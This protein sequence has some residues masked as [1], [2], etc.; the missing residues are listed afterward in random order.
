[1]GK[2]NSSLTRVKPLGDAIINNHHLVNKLLSLVMQDET[3]DFGEFV[4]C[5]I[6]YMNYKDGEEKKKEK[7]LEPSP[8]HL[9]AIID[10]ILKDEQFRSYVRKRDKSTNGNKIK[11]NKL[12][13]LDPEAK[14]VA[15]SC[16]KS[17]W[18]K[19]ETNSYPDLFI[20][21]DK[22]IIVIEGKRTEKDITSST[23]YL[24]NSSQMTRHIENALYYL[25]KKNETKRV[26]GFY[27]VEDTCNY[28]EHCTREYFRKSLDLETIQKDDVLKSTISNS[29]YGYTT[30]QEISKKLK[31]VYPKD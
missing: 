23:A 12:F 3:F 19:F 22:N 14:K 31:I 30:W 18:N 25:H 11:R 2:L 29:F 24:P 13:D 20:E 10:R 5:N 7:V 26:I 27:I 8:S 28:K 16:F 4:G 21:N 1:M 17:S 6:F 15:K 9:T